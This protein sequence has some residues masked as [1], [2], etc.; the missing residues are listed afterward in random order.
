[1]GLKLKIKKNNA[2]AAPAQSGAPSVPNL[3]A[4]AGAPLPL[5]MEPSAP[6]LPAP[7]R[8]RDGADAGAPPVKK[9][10][11][12]IKSSVK[13]TPA[14]APAAAPALPPPTFAV[15]SPTP[16]L[17]LAAATPAQQPR[18]GA[19]RKLQIKR[20]LVPSAPSTIPPAAPPGGKLEPVKKKIK[21]KLAKPSK[22]LTMEKK[23]RPLGMAPLAPPPLTVA[24]KAHAPQLTPEKSPLKLK[25]KAPAK[26][27]L[28]IK[29]P[30]KLGGGL[31]PA[32]VPAMKP[33]IVP[34]APLGG[35]VK[36]RQKLEKIA[37]AQV[38]SCRCPVSHVTPLSWN[39]VKC[40]SVSIVFRECCHF[41]GTPTGCT[42]ACSCSEASCASSTS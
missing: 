15:E 29:T 24:N 34:V 39:S 27:T 22:P 7:K 36:R 26:K 25:L 14:A 42:T 23:P 30:S 9:R 41:A 2:H 37:D 8:E 10:L 16:A 32:S 6:Q 31:L 3:G 18:P 4:P 5:A 35:K 11:I 28:K 19:P 17:P 1:M 38:N 13:A 21:L 12:K 33:A 20:P 40:L